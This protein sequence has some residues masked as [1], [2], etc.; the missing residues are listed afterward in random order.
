[1]KKCFY[2]VLSVLLLMPVL[3]FAQT[4]SSMRSLAVEQMYEYAQAVYQRG[5]Y[6]QAAVIFRRIL[7]MKPDHEGA[8]EFATSLNKKG[9]H[10]VIPPQKDRSIKDV[11]VLEE[12]PAKNYGNIYQKTS[13]VTALETTEE[14]HAE[15]AIEVKAIS[16]RD[17][18]QDMDDTDEAILRLKK[19][20]AELR[21]QI[22]QGQSEF[23]KSK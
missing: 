10:I 12:K 17:L 8:V 6:A 23:N 16:N 4:S 14:K 7:A 22:A 11:V 15:P 5:D 18:K 3:A 21:G 19:E 9:Q 13:T 1:M 2:G 20:I